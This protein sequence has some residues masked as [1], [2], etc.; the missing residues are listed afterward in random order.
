MASPKVWDPYLH[1]V[2]HDRV[3]RDLWAA[4]DDRHRLALPHEVWAKKYRVRRDTFSRHMG[5]MRA[6]GR[7]RKVGRTHVQQCSVCIYEVVD[8]A[9]YDPA[10]PTTHAQVRTSVQ[11]G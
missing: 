5:V 2:P 6:E 7:L 3:H 11:W 9:T 4:A 10:D 1:R 8:P